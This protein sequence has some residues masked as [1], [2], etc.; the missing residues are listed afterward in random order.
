MVSPTR[1]R[2]LLSQAF[3]SAMKYYVTF[4]DF[5]NQACSITSG[6]PSPARNSRQTRVDFG[7]LGAIHN[8]NF[9]Y[10]RA[11]GDGHIGTIAAQE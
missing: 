9:L 4:S 6:R 8:V 7:T 3:P 2:F 11:Y 1:L 10:K 5:A